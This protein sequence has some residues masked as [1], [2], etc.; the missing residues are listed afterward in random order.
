M[1]TSPALSS[2]YNT[3]IGIGSMSSNGVFLNSPEA[4]RCAERYARKRPD[5][6]SHSACTYRARCHH[7]DIDSQHC[8]YLSRNIGG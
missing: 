3:S 4:S 7:C 2:T 6:H 5:D 1:S 8:G